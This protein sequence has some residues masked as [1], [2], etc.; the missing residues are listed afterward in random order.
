MSILDTKEYPTEYPPEAVRVLNTMTIPGSQLKILGSASL[1]SQ[2]YAGDYDG[3]DV[4][5]GDLA[6]LIG[7]FQGIIRKLKTLPHAYIGDIKAG[8]VEDWRVVPPNT[9][10]WKAKATHKIEHLL[11]SGIITSKEA[12]EAP[13]DNYLIAKNSIKFH[14]IRWTPEEVLQGHKQIRDGSTYTLEAAFHA[15]AV[16]KVDVIGKVGEK[17]TDFSVIYEFHDANGRLNKFPMEPTAS[18]KEDIKYYTLIGNP[19]KAVKRKFALAKLQNDLPALKRYNKIINSE[20]GKLYLVYSEVKTLA[21][22]LEEGK[23]ISGIKAR[24]KTLGLPQSL[25]A[26]IEKV[27]DKSDYPIL[28][29]IEAQVLEH[30]SKGTRLKGGGFA[31]AYSPYK[32]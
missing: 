18:I 20:L 26:D 28:R 10:D 32:P 30:L 29:H 6:S 1:K 16:V 4:A 22:L 31:N 3:Y 8:E 17:Y 24:L 2:K 25:E 23:D 5:T 11:K 12:Q 13:L 27:K 21:D 9:K 19:F 15:P 7:E 14:V